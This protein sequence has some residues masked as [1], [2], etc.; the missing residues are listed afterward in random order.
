MLASVTFNLQFSCVYA[1][2][3]GSTNDQAVLNDAVE[4]QHFEVS[5]SKY[6]LS[7][8]GYVCNDMVL[9]LYQGYWYHLKES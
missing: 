8:A 3:E 2:W 1:G 7:D 6:Y 4:K 9:S 5:T